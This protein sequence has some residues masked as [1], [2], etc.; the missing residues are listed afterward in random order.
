MNELERWANFYLLTSAAAATLIGLMFVVITLAAERRVEGGTAKIGLY[1]TPTIVYFGSVVGVAALLTFP[2]HSR[3]TATLCICLAGVVGLVYSGTSLIGGGDKKSF[4]ERHDLIFYAIVPFVA[5]G[6]LVVG[7]VLLIHH[8]QRGLTFV[9]V[10]MLALL[11]LG[12]RNSWAIAI[13]VSTRPERQN[14]K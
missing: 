6:L 9:A 7:A 2:N 14:S 1:L 5:Y 12:I 13:D 11:T 8:P 10:G 3:F 4:E